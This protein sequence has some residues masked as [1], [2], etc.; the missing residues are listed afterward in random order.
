MNTLPS[1]VRPQLGLVCI[2]A[3]DQIRFRTITRTRLLQLD[4][5]ERPPILSA[6]YQDNLNRV[7]KAIDFCAERGIG[8]YRLSSNLMPFADDPAYESILMEC[9]FLMRQIGQRARHRRIRLLVHPEQ[10][11]VLSSDNP[12][13]VENSIGT[14]RMHARMLD[15]M[16]QPRSHACPMVLHGGKSD[17]PDALVRVIDGLEEGIRARLILE[18]D[19]D[20]YSSAEIVA[21]CRRANVPMVFDAH[22]HVCHEK[23]N[24]Y[25]DESVAEMFRA[26][27]ATWP[28]PQWQLTHISNGREFFNDTRHSDLITQMPSVFRYAPWIEV[29]AKA[30]EEA[31]ALL[32]ARWLDNLPAPLNM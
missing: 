16:E 22:H 11:I 3:S 28:Q 4:E 20:A 23:L 6:I 14:L 9:A 1:S 17:R 21:V 26:A 27:R 29:E 19:E 5:A 12:Q 13:V 8:M 18:N 30:K 25:E 2:T 10:F 7:L 24:S 15:M 31:I 32:Q